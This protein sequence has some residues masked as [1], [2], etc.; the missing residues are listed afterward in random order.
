MHMGVN[1]L[2]HFLLANLLLPELKVGLGKGDIG[3][4]VYGTYI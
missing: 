4:S 2:G 1:F 3:A